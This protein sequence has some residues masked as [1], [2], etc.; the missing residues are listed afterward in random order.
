MT[1]FF[2]FEKG[3]KREIPDFNV[4]FR[5][6]ATYPFYSDCVWFLTQMRRWGQIGE[7]KADDWYDEVAKKVYRPDIWKEAAELL[8]KEGKLPA[9]EIPETDGY[10]AP[11]TEFIDGIEYDGK[12]PN[13]YLAKF[14][15]GNKDE[16]LATSE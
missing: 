10:K 11:T 4:F 9:S 2:E 7:P 6:N 15:I 12:K 5:H 1:G 8:V 16:S 13:A 14:K 3:D